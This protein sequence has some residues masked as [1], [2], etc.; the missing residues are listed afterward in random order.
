MR[1]HIGKAL[2]SR[3]Q[4]IKNALDKY[5]DAARALK[6]PHPVLEW[7]EVVEYAFLSEFDI[8]SETHMDICMKPWANPAARRVMDMYFKIQRAKEEVVRLNVELKRLV[9]FMRDEVQYLEAI[10]AKLLQEQPYL[11]HI[12]S[13]WLCCL[14]SFNQHHEK[15]LEKLH[16]PAGFDI[17]ALVPGCAVDPPQLPDPPLELTSSCSEMLRPRSPQPPDSEPTVF[18]KDVEEITE[19]RVEEQVQEILEDIDFLARVVDTL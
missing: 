8:L 4:A 10:Q 13:I 11:A 6:P 9:T 12:L 14:Q 1:Q 7:E 19:D 15:N 2:K 16:S 18:D 5:N 17:S 3:S